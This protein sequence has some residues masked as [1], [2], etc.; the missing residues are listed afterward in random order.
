MPILRHWRI[1]ELEG[2]DA[3]A[4][5]ARRRLA[6]HLAKLDAAATR[7]EEKVATLERAAD[8]L[9]RASARGGTGLAA[10]PERR[11]G[12]PIDRQRADAS[13]SSQ[14]TPIRS[15]SS[16]RRTPARRG[17]RR[18]GR[19]RGGGTGPGSGEFDRNA[20]V[21]EVAEQRDRPDRQVD[22]EVDD[23]PA[24]HDARDPEPR[25]ASQDDPHADHRR[26]PRRRRPGSAR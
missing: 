20:T 25:A 24:E 1:F 19:A 23:H 12:R 18:P 5:D 21:V 2:L 17:S 16:R 7:F 4:E 14:T 11:V 9:E 15:T 26:R 22:D 8:R 3:A 10:G 6:E 13:S